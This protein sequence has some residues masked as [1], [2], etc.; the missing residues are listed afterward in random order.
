MVHQ[1]F[2]VMIVNDVN[3]NVEVYIQ[4][5][6]F[7]KLCLGSMEIDCVISELCHNLIKGQ[8]FKEL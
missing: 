6:P 7:I 5:C 4:Y 8:F 3:L 2:V 1:Q